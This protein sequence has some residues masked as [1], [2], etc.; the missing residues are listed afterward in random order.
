MS[1][2]RLILLLSFM[3]LLFLTGAHLSATN[4]YTTRSDIEKLIEQGEELISQEQF[5][6]ATTYLTQAKLKAEKSDLKDLLY[7]VNI[8]LAIVYYSIG[9]TSSSMLCS[10][11]AL[12]L[13]ETEG[14]D[15]ERRFTALNGVAG[16]YYRM[17][18]YREAHDYTEQC[19]NASLQEGDSVATVD[20]ALNLIRICCREQLV[21]Q[22]LSY[23]SIV[24]QWMP[25]EYLPDIAH[26][27]YDVEMEMHFL[28]HNYATAQA[29]ADTL[30]ALPN[31][32]NARASA[33]YIQFMISHA[34]GHG[35]EATPQAL[36]AIELSSAQRRSELYDT[37]SCIYSRA[38]QTALALQYKDSALHQGRLVQEQNDRQ[39]LEQ[40]RIQVEAYK[41]RQDFDQQQ[42]RLAHTRWVAALLVNALIVVLMIVW[43]TIRHQRHKTRRQ[44]KAKNEELNTATMITSSRNEVVSSLIDS[45]EDITD[46]Q[47]N[48]HVKALIANLRQQL[49]DSSNQ[50]D[51]LIAF[52]Q[53]NPNFVHNITQRHPDLLPGDLQFMAYLLQSNL[54]TADIAS[55]LNIT[56]DSCKRKKL[57]LARKL[58]L[59]SSTEL[60]DYLSSF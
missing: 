53:A 42:E 44:L 17:K 45:L 6:E 58:G 23:D 35:L 20:F 31:H 51:F 47:Q 41:I 48:E 36:K 56:H 57:R 49:R 29:Y 22:A 12:H 38:G 60:F 30:L 54:S 39:M 24:E 37:L 4:R 10:Q 59:Q 26:V 16:C 1:M 50:D 27:K 14:Y 11:E 2:Q 21:S 8:N 55:L 33:A 13:A 40:S 32:R 25:A 18:Q 28:N 15:W 7:M 9:Q 5:T 3:A 52:K 46:I 34:Q 19:L 43:F